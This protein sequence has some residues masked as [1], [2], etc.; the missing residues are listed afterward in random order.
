M[1][2]FCRHCMWTPVLSLPLIQKEPPGIYTAGL[3][4]QF[5]FFAYISFFNCLFISTLKS[6]PY[7]VPSTV[8]AQNNPHA[9]TAMSPSAEE[10]NETEIN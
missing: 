8:Y 6:D 9:Y 2:G 1:D 7:P 3:D 10:A 5:P 4:A